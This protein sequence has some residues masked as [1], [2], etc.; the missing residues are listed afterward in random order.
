MQTAARRFGRRCTAVVRMRTV[1]VAALINR[2]AGIVPR[3]V[4]LVVTTALV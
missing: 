3:R 2:R 1:W 4:M